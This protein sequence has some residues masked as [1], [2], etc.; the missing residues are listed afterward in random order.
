MNAK[1]NIFSIHKWIHDTF[2]G[3]SPK[4]FIEL[5]ANDGSDT[6]ILATVPNVIIHALE[7]DPRMR[8]DPPSNVRFY[9]LAISD[10]NGTAPFVLSQ[11]H[12]VFPN[13]QWTVSSSLLKPKTHL[14]YFPEVHFGA[15]VV[16]ETIT[17]DTLCSQNE[18]SKVDLIWADVQGAEGQMI[19]GGTSTLKSTKYLYT[20]YSNNELYE[21]QITLKTILQLLPSWEIVQN[22]PVLNG[23]YGDV[24]LINKECT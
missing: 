7:P 11:S 24:L 18:I 9:P 5:G 20:E 2:S 19:A 15:T 13:A 12:D 23:I 10:K 17:L 4:V 8:L 3:D 6:R 21:G 14:K 16:V 22:N 1:P